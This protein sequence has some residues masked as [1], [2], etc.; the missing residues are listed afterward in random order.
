[1]VQNGTIVPEGL[2][3]CW[4]HPTLDNFSHLFSFFWH[5]LSDDLDEQWHAQ[6]HETFQVIRR[7]LPA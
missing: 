1:V 4:E 6:F 2:P 3:D 7:R 5:P